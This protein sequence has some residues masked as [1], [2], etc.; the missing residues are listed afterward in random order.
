MSPTIASS[1]SRSRSTTRSTRGA[2][3][4]LASPTATPEV[5]LARVGF[6]PIPPGAKAG[7]DHADVFR[8]RGRIYVA[9]TGAD[10]IEVVD[11]RTR[12]YLRALPAE[13]P[14]VAGVLIVEEHDLL[15]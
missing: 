4:R 15:F 11:S 3:T 1:S 8:S 14:G 5:G 9:H 10:R 13:L 6:V 12:S 2:R 7:F